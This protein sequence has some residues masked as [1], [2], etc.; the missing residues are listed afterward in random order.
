MPEH[1][2]VRPDD[3]EL[4]TSKKRNREREKHKQKQSK[5]HQEVKF[6]KEEGRR[7]GQEAQAS[8]QTMRGDGFGRRMHEHSL[9]VSNKKV[10]LSHAIEL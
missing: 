6:T 2:F 7:E 8:V 3:P 4:K 5:G 1:C 9:Q 10:A